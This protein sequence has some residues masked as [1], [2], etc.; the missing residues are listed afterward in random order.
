MTIPVV[1]K[2]Y[3]LD[4]TSSVVAIKQELANCSRNNARRFHGIELCQRSG[5]FAPWTLKLLPKLRPGKY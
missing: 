4:N 3:D 1:V 2:Q 5:L